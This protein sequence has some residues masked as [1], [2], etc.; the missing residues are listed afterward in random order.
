ME[1]NNLDEVVGTIMKKIE[2]SKKELK[3]LNM[4]ILGKTGVGKS[5]LINNMF[6]EP[7]ATTGVGRPVTREIHKYEVEN[8]PLTIYDTPG[9][10][11]GGNNSMESLLN[12]VVQVIKDGI[13]TEDINNAIHCI[14]YCVSTAN[15]RFEDAEKEFINNFLVKTSDF[16]VPVIIVLTKSYSDDDAMALKQAIENENLAISGIVPVVAADYK[17]NG[18]LVRE[19]YGLDILTEMISNV[20]PEALQETFT[21]IQ[22]VNIKMKIKRANTIV[23]VSAAASVG[24]CAIPIPLS[25][26]ALL[27]PEQIG[28]LVGITTA[29]GL[30]VEK[31]TLAAIISATIGTTGATVLGKSAV[32][33]IFK[34]IPGIGSLAGVALSGGV[35]ATITTA[36]GE[37]YIGVMT[38]IYKGEM[39]ISELSTD[40][41]RMKIADL[42]KQKL[43]DKK[44]K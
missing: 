27:V 12:E 20:I 35:A 40:E 5:T 24:L 15:A 43:G 7:I 4:M 41:G 33:A 2:K 16:K 17:I 38:L 21:S 6:S 25:D 23:G 8:F 30:P 14:L 29:F 11:L 18:V 44:T 36:L 9:L 32:S 26:A 34:L 19:A 28:M 1:E 37:A 42:F 3:K 13:S 10:E 22:K 31:S 39:N